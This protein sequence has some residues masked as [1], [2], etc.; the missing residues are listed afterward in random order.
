MFWGYL[1]RIL[2]HAKC[3]YAV[4]LT[5]LMDILTTK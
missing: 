1:W 2:A 5:E 3:K 4:V